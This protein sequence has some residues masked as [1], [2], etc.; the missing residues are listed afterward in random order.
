MATGRVNNPEGKNQYTNKS[1]KITGGFSREYLEAKKLESTAA[2]ANVVDRATELTNI[3]FKSMSTPQAFGASLTTLGATAVG[4]T[5]KA[6]GLGFK[7]KSYEDIAKGAAKIGVETFSNKKLEE[8][9][10]STDTYKELLK[11][12]KAMKASDDAYKRALTKF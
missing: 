10:K 9:V 12:E 4:S 5:I 3:G 8:S 11:A 6:S 7:D 1:I 2:K